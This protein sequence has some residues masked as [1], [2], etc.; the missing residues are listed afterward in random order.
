MN[1]A[2]Y[3][4]ELLSDVVVTADSANE[5]GHTGL[6]YLPGSLFL[7]AAALLANRAGQGFD[8]ARFLSGRIR[9][10]NAY[11]FASGQATYPMP[12]CFFSQKGLEWE[13][14]KPLNRLSGSEPSGGAQPKQWRQGY[15]TS[16][17]LVCEIKLQGQ[18]KTAIDRE[19]RR[20]KEGALYSYSSIPAGRVFLLR[21]QFDDPAD[22]EWVDRLFDGQTIRLGRSRSAEFGSVLMKRL[23]SPPPMAAIPRENGDKV[24][25]YLASDLAL[26]RNGMPVLIPAAAEFGL[27]N[28]IFAPELS[29]MLARRYSPWNAFYNSRM[30]ERQV[31]CKGSVVVFRLSGGVDLKSIQDRFS[32]GW[33]RHVEEGLGQIL[34]NPSWLLD[35][36]ALSRE[37]FAAKPAVANPATSMIRYLET[38]IARRALS[39][40]AFSRGVEWAKDWSDLSKKIDHGGAKVP[41]KAQWANIRI[42]A[43]RCQAKPADL[44][45]M[46]KD[47]CTEGLRRKLWVEASIRGKGQ[48]HCLYDAI[49]VK[50]GGQ[51]N[52]KTCLTL[53][54]A[55]VEMGRLLGRRSDSKSAGAE[56]RSAS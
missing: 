27:E 23:K 44:S 14:N 2:V 21:L 1:E 16:Q 17:G 12:L 20:S 41:G 6:D 29:S 39:T 36:P 30:T 34:V 54:H 46:L 38:K 56:G 45:E 25:L 8:P 55:A 28:A 51:P 15:M 26:V 37:V 3:S 18:M 5:G 7:G 31:L 50:I 13:A 40:E 9:F 4:V 47:Y 11:P 49:K 53:Y 52:E 19:A 48:T 35:A 33:G 32:R 43:V 10:L 24:V 42:A 22:L